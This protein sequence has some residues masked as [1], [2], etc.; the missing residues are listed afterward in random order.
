MKH[1]ATH[2]KY[3]VKPIFYTGAPIQLDQRI[4]SKKLD[5]G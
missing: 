2:E 1:N 3:S 4:T 5:Y